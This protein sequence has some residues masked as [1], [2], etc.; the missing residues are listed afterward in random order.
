MMLHEVAILTLGIAFSLVV[1]GV[2]IKSALWVG[3]DARR[4]GFQHTRLIQLAMLLQF[5]VPLIAYWTIT[6][7]MDNLS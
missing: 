1:L 4:R 2:M 3:R 7:N 6:R 5:P